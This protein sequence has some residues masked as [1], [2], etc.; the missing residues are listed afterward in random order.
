MLIEGTMTDAQG[1]VTSFEVDAKV[2]RQSTP[3]PGADLTAQGRL[4]WAIQ[5][6]IAVYEEGDL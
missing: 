3:A 4:L 6:L 2:N 1:R 5:E